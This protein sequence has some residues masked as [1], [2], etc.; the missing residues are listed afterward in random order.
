[1]TAKVLDGAA[2]ARTIRSEVA[3]QVDDLRRRTGA[4]PRLAAVLV[5]DDPASLTYVRNKTAA[6]AEAG[7]RSDTVRIEATAGQEEI[8]ARVRALNADPDIDA[9]LV[10]LPLPRGIERATI[11]MSIDPAKD[12]DGLHP[13]N[14]GRLFMRLEAPV[15]C[16]PA[17]VVE[18]LDRSGL[19]IAG[20]RAAI[21]GRSEIVGRPLAILLMMRDATVTVCHSKTKDLAAITSEAE[22]LVAAI[23]RPAFVRGE[24]IRPGAVVIDVGI[25]RVDD[26]ALAA[27]IFGAGSERVRQVRDRGYTL[28]GDVHPLEAAGRASHLTPVPGGVGPLTIA[29]L[30]R[31]TLQ[32]AS[33]RRG[34]ADGGAGTIPEAGLR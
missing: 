22:I 3:R 26:P 21:V 18:L 1:M 28:V 20:R 13:L 30:L 31:N 33:R 34:G 29:C 16:T 25:N 10:Q 14:A 9:I 23:G 27:A 7:I 24:H 17:G 32:A 2:V 5:G 19:P 15:P 6:C 8:L 11:I 12:A 4:T